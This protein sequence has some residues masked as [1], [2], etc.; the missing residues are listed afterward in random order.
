MTGFTPISAGIGGGMIG[1]AVVA[2]MISIGRLAGISGIAAGALEL[3]RG[4]WTWQLSF[5]IGLAAAP[6]LMHLAGYPLPHPVMPAS[7]ALIVGA[8][9]LV[10]FGTR[11]GG[12]CTS[13]HG[14]CGLARLS[15]RSILATAIFMVVALIVVALIRHVIGGTL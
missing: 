13:G 2:L 12:G 8:G 10:G 3:R 6:P 15:P 14:I 5:L 1:L 7:L 11:L 9:L 4:E